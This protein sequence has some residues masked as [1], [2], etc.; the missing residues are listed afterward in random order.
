MDS[1]LPEDREGVLQRI[2][3]AMAAGVGWNLECRIRRPDG[4][5]RWTGVS[6]GPQVER[7]PDDRARMG[8]RTAEIV[9]DIIESQPGAG[10]RVVLVFPPAPGLHGLRE[11]P[12]GGK[13]QPGKALR[14]LLVDDE[15]T[16]RE[17]V[18]RLLAALGHR[19]TEA[20][21]GLE[22]LE[23]LREGLDTDLVILDLN[24]PRMDG[25][26]TLQRLRDLRTGLPALLATGYADDR[27]PG[28]L[29]RHD[30]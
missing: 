27:V 11:V 21:G 8:P 2:R 5:V 14:I 28:I 4:E 20:P 7:G 23:R 30:F 17:G 19:V 15:D 24:M 16:I 26:E 29:E 3:E 10:T 25:S 13:A 22:A 9:Q 12:T 1:V 6:G 18:A